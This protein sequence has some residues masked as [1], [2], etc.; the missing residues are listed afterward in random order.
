[1]SAEV[2]PADDDPTAETTDDVV[3]VP[4]PVLSPPRVVTPDRPRARQSEDRD[5]FVPA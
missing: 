4:A 2:L 1:M 5:G 3:P